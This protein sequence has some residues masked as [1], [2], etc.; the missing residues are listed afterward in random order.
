MTAAT[1]ADYKRLTTHDTRHTTADTRR[2]TK[3]TRATGASHSG[4]PANLVPCRAYLH[5]FSCL[6]KLAMLLCLK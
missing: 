1:L 3:D 2:A 4:G 6:M 5:M